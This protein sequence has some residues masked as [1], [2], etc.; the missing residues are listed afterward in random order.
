MITNERQYRITHAQTE[1]L[2]TALEK[3]QSP[4]AAHARSARLVRAHQDALRSQLS[5]LREELAQYDALR[6]GKRR[7]LSA[8]S[9]E[10]L[11]MVLIQARIAAGL[12][13]RELGEKLRIPEQQVQRYEATEYASASIARIS[14]V[15]DALGLKLRGDVVL[16]RARVDLRSLVRRLESIGLDRTFLLDRILPRQL[17]AQ[18]RERGE[19]AEGAVLQAA[20]AVGRVFGWTTD[21]L[22]GDAPL[23]VSG[24]ALA[25][26]RFKVAANVDRTRLHAYTL[27]AHYLAILLVQ[28]T[29]HL[30]IK[31]I[32]RDAAEVRH[33]LVRDGGVDFARALS[34]VWDLGIPVLPLADTGAFHG[35]CWRMSGRNVIALKQRTLSS[36]RWL[37]DLLHE[38]WH[39][40]QD[41]AAER[42]SFIESDEERATPEAFAAEQAAMQF[43]GDVLLDGRAEQIAQR[44]VTEARGRLEFLK[45][46]TITVA[47]AEKVRVDALANY[48]AFRLAL[49][50]ESWWGTANN[51]QELEPN[52]FALARDALLARA[53]LQH[54]NETDRDILLRALA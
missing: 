49:Q 21:A 43:A 35:A 39:L 7:V 8:A 26:A 31:P 33:A 28:A 32:P 23:V 45:R 10:E 42:L 19:S 5:E 9:F 53:D 16:P 29:T 6:S 2:A 11:P 41:A 3:A 13:Q 27:Y 17:A 15:A 46:V 18:L 25:G 34:F 54:M 30:P 1:K 52:P 51:L 50:G 47:H 36:A 40:G 4:Q 14:E 12:T 22:F 24:P 38:L 44:A 37:F 20:A 48:L